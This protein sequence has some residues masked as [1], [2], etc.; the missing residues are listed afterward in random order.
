MYIKGQR[1]M[2]I[3]R[4]SIDYDKLPDALLMI[5]KQQIRIDGQY[6]DAFVL[7][8]LKRAIGRFENENGAMLNKATW[9]WMPG[10]WEFCSNRARVPVTPVTSFSAA[11]ADDTDVT[12]NYTI[13]TDSVTGVPILYLNGAYA[14]GVV[15]TLQTGFTDETLPP[16]ALDVVLRTAAHLHEHREILIPGTEFVAPDLA[17]DATWWVPHV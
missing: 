10:Q 14:S 4:T 15:L 17:R 9:E 2:S 8:V 3:V 6:E 12:A 1:K 13:S 5:A 7:S 11:L 16:S